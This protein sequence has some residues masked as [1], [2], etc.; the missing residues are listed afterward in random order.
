MRS[1]RTYGRW[2]QQSAAQQHESCRGLGLRALICVVVRTLAPVGT[3]FP[4]TSSFLPNMPRKPF[5]SSTGAFMSTAT[6]RRCTAAAF[7]MCA[8]GAKHEALATAPR[9]TAERSIGRED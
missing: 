6:L 7:G 9:R 5:F 8:A 2:Q 4:L 1:E 3:T